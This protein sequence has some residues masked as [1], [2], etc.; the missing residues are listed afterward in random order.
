LREGVLERRWDE[1]GKRGG[2]NIPYIEEEEGIFSVTKKQWERIAREEEEGSFFEVRSIGME[3]RK[4]LE[5][6]V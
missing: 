6:R 5:V 3:V 4:G 1:N 2:D